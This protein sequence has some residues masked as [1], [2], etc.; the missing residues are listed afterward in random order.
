MQ[1]KVRLD[2]PAGCLFDERQAE[3]AV[4]FFREHLR[5][6][7]G[8][9]AGRPFALIP[10]QEHDIREIYGRVNPDGTRQVRLVYKEVPKKNGK[11]EEAAGHA[12]KLLFADDEPSAEIYG[13][14]ADRDQASIVFNV[15]AAMVRHNPKLL[16]RSRVLDGVK[17]I[18]VPSE[19]S[20]YR[21]VSSKVASKHGYNSHGVIFDEIHAQA[22]MDLWEVLTFG[23]GAARMQPLTIGITTAG[24]PG[25]SP[26]AEMLHGEADQ[27]LRGLIPCPSH[28]YPVMYAAPDDADWTDEDVWR[29]CNPLLKA[30]VMRIESI[31]EEFEDARRR[32]IMQNSFRRLRLNQWVAQVVRWI[33]MDSWD[34]CAKPVDLRA[35][36]DLP[37]YVG[38]DLSTKMDVTAVVLVWF[39]GANVFHVLPLFFIPRDTVQDRPNIEADKYRVWIREGHITPTPGSAVEFD[40]VRARIN[41]LASEAGLNIRQIAIDPMFALQ[42]GQQLEADGFDVVFVRQSA[43]NFTEPAQELEGALQDGRVRHGGNPVLRWMADC[44]EVKQFPDGS[45]RPMKPER[46]KS[47]KR[48]DGIVAM[49][50]AIGRALLNVQGPSPWADPVTA[51][52]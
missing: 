10:E 49:V 51:V 16:Q 14:A 43:R 5:H 48:I 2:R 31:R 28:F 33:Q 27:I 30:G 11:S 1:R 8:R 50:M 35:L 18:V 23:A 12:L 15:A 47:R 7:K 19:E 46:F 38:V 29:D 24:I 40:V 4:R 42:L 32:P 45:V 26:V 13:A 17:R 36:K 34:A 9:F 41:S 22:N 3:R 37:C 39:D 25:D 20:F 6:T 52:M 44:V 21:A